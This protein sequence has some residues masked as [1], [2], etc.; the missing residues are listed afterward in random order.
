MKLEAGESAKLA[1]NTPVPPMDAS[2]TRN[3]AE[4]SAHA[5]NRHRFSIRIQLASLVVACVL[6]VWIASGFLVYYNYQSRRA[7]TEQRMLETSRALTLVVDRDLANMEASLND[8]ATS[9]SLV[10]GDLPAFYL[11]A[12]AHLVS[13]ARPGSDIILSDE[14]GQELINTFRPFGAPLPK[15]GSLEGVRQVFATGRPV[16]ANVYKGA[17][18][19][20]LGISVDV[21]VFRDGRVVYDLAMGVPPEWFASVLMQQHLPPEWIGSIF[22]NNRTLVARTR[23]A[24]EFAGRSLGPSLAQGMRDRAEGTAEV[25]NFEGVPVFDSFSRSETSGWTIVIGVPKATMMAEIWHWL[26]WTVVCTAL[27]SLAGIGLAMLLARRIAGSIQGLIAPAL[28]LGRGEPVTIGQLKLAETNEVGESLIK[29]SLLIQQRAAE[30]ERT[31]S[32]RREAE[33][34]KRFNAELELSE[35]AARARATELAAI[36]DAVPAATFIGHDPECQRMTSNHAA[37]GLFRMPPGANAS[38]SAPNGAGPSNYQMLRDGRKLSPNE[39]PVQLAAATG[40][41]IRDSEYTIAFDDGSSRCILGNAVPLFD[42]AG[43]V[44]GAVGAFIDITERKHAETELLWKSAFMEAQSNAT[45]DGILVVNGDAEKIFCDEPFLKMWK[46]PQHIANE[47]SDALQLEYVASLT[48]DSDKFWKKVLYLYDHPEETS[49]DEI[50]LRNGT[51][52]DRYSAPVLGKS[53][54]HYGR[55]WTFRDMTERRQNVDAL[56]ESELRFRSVVEGAPIGIYIQTDGILRYLNPSALRMFGAENIEQIVGQKLFDRIHPDSHQAVIERAQTVTQDG[57][58]VP[59]L[60]ERHLRLDGSVFDTENSAEPFFFEGRDGVIVFFRD[61]TERK[62]EENGRRELEQQLRQAQ[63]MEAV[64]RLAGGIAHDF[65][66]LL[67]GHTKLH[68]DA[69]R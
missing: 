5:K 69:A 11:R 66:N 51:I 32:V 1:S 65:N 22:D 60:E 61:I 31:Q 13:S 17:T 24:T 47:K 53:G 10:A 12:H 54:K 63:K 20:R 3:A 23:L 55:I 58:A 18:T 35:A 62:R 39:M 59:P 50:A 36:M 49:R 30:R 21:P 37:C 42:E 38:M 33:D 28:A 52:L 25:I 68:G 45:G 41:E 34:L 16:I 9:T 64:G 26:T 14:T 46:I 56:R 19:R 57:K 67:I 4:A 7:L 6:P 2:G 29:A 44:R 8:L 43:K 15:R 48:K 27:L 40:R